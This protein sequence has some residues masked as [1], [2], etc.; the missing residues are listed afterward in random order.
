VS[1]QTDLLE[2]VD[3]TLEA[4][5]NSVQVWTLPTGKR[6]TVFRG[7]PPM[8]ELIAILEREGLL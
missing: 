3:A 8:E 5:P 7:E 6:V 4:S 1:E 2:G